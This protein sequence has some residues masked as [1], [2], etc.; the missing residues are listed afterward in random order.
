M[1]CYKDGID[2]ECGSC[3]MIVSDGSSSR[4]SRDDALTTRDRFAMSALVGILSFEGP[5]GANR[6]FERVLEDAKQAYRYADAM[7]NARQK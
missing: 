1:I 7:L 3:R 4:C 5:H 2:S 6:Y